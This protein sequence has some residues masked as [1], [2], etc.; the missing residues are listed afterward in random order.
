MSNKLDKLKEVNLLLHKR[1]RT[2]ETFMF[3]ENHNM[4]SK[5][6]HHMKKHSNENM[7]QTQN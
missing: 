6:T 1:I 5:E 4:L 2:I 3:I 7:K